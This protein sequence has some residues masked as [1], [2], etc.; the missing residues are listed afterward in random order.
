MNAQYQQQ[1]IDNQQY[2]APVA[3]CLTMEEVD[4]LELCC[5]ANNNAVSNQHTECDICKDT[6]NEQH[7]N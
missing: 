2:I 1:E 3:R 5:V 7:L 4:S 6:L